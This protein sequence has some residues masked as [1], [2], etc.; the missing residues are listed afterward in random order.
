[1]RKLFAIL[2]VAITAGLAGTVSN[3]SA[4]ICSCDDGG[5][6]NYPYMYYCGPNNQYESIAH[7][8]RYWTCV[9]DGYWHWV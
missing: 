2:A 6:A 9:W 4:Q 1:M 7:A 3:A 8:G 5:S